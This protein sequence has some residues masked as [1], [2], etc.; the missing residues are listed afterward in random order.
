[1][2]EVI[3]KIEARQEVFENEIETI[4]SNIEDADYLQRIVNQLKGELLAGDGREES[5]EVKF[6]LLDEGEK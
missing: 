2:I 6:E 4:K 5:I 1:M 3:T